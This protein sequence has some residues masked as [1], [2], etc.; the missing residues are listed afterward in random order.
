M[1]TIWSSRKRILFFGLPLSFTKYTLTDEKFI[2][3]SG[4]LTST[5]DEIRLYRIVDLSLKRGLGQKIFGLGTITIYTKDKS[6]EVVVLKNVKDS[7][8]VK[9]LI[10]DCVEKERVKKRVVSRDNM[11]YD[12]DHYDDDYDDH[13]DEDDDYDDR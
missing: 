3:N 9:E 1:R 4:F 6:A 8:S 11:G 5:E 12:L 10:S 2:I 7:S 13:Y